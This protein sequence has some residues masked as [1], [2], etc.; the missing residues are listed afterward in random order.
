M[1]ITETTSKKQMNFKE[2]KKN[3]W[4]KLFQLKNLIKDEQT[5][6]DTKS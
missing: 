1:G 2:I 3:I 4:G 6:R 5:T